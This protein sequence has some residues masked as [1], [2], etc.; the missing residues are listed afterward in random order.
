[1]T[2][3]ECESLLVV[4]VCEGRQYIQNAEKKVSN[5]DGKLVPH[6]PLAVY[7]T[8]TLKLNGGRVYFYP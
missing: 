1:M 4:I 5:T 3:K 6:F 2:D 8:L 7:S